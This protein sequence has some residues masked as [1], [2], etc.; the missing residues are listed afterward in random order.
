MTKKEQLRITTVNVIES[1]KENFN[2]TEDFNDEEGRG[3]FTFGVTENGIEY[4]FDMSRRDFSVISY[5]V[6]NEKGY[7]EST[8]LEKILEFFIKNEVQISNDWI[9][10]K[11][12]EMSN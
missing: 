7:E 11:V 8:K 2:V 10:L 1:V 4:R 3:Y 9:E 6:R 5:K 12:V